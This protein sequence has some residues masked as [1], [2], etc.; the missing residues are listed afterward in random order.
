VTFTLHRPRKSSL[1]RARG[2][3]FASARPAEV[4]AWNIRASTGATTTYLGG[5]PQASPGWL[6]IVRSGSRVYVYDSPDGVTWTAHGSVTFPT[7]S[8]YIGLVVCSHDTANVSTATFD[9]V[10]VQ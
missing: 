8:A 9:N 7:G 4:G 1:R 6:K 3:P 2:I 10:V 5:G